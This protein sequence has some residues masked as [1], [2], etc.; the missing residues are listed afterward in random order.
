MSRL[1]KIVR[2]F[3]SHHRA[4]LSGF[5]AAIFLLA[6]FTAT[7]YW[8]EY[9]Y[10]YSVRY[11]TPL[12]LL[13][14]E[15]DLAQG[16]FPYGFFAAK[17]GFITFLWALI[18]MTGDGPVALAVLR[19]VF[20]GLTLGLAAASY[21]VVR[22]FTVNKREALYTTF[23]LLLLPVPLYLG[24]K[25]LSEVPSLLLATIACWQFLASFESQS[26]RSVAVRVFIAA[27]ALSL[28]TLFRFPTGL[29]FGGMIV[30]L[31][32][33]PDKRF[34]R[35]AVAVRAAAVVGLHFVLAGV[36]YMAFVGLPINRFE[37]VVE[38]VTNRRPGIMLGI[39]ALILTLQLFAIPLAVTLL[40]RWTPA[41]KS[42]CIWL[43]ICTLPIFASSYIEPRY[44]YMGLLPLAMLASA[45]LR[46]LS[47]RL[48]FAQGSLILCVMLVVMD[49]IGFAPLMPYL[50]NENDY[51][52]LIQMT[53]KQRSGGTYL[54]PYMADYCFLTFVYPERPLVLTMSRTRSENGR[55][56][57]T[58][59]FR[60]WV[61]P[62]R[63]SGS[64]ETLSDIPQPWIYVGWTY[65]PSVLALKERLHPLGIGYIE[66]IETNLK[67]R[68][69]LEQSWIWGNKDLRLRGIAGVGNYYGYRVLPKSQDGGIALHLS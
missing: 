4:L 62:G 26:S 54:V 44:F 41:V 61:R 11:H 12:E 9:F 27:N 34:S 63:Y 40:R 30:A 5:V 50:I 6:S 51:A 42:A 47:A 55:V 24:F 66:R 60:Q 7:H 28:A 45:G 67:L 35:R 37:G 1:V 20:A 18:K 23:V 25:T 15:G 29:V 31:L 3:P 22:F 10:L 33:V 59:G 68:N 58:A 13:N 14:I 46:I 36:V 64:L 48:R 38:S 57:E 39:Y 69:H 52:R 17:L 2:G 43:A 16:L 19:L 21:Q 56:F 49:R 8:D 65:N 53:E 32:V